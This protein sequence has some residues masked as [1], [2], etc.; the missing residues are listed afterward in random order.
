[1]GDAKRRKQNDPN[2]GKPQV[3]QGELMI[4]YACGF[5]QYSVPAIESGWLLA[6]VEGDRSYIALPALG[7]LR[8]NA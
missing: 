3:F 8:L 7:C 6:I 5:Q 1:M 2:Y 4:C